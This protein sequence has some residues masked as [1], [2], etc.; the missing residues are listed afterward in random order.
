M[1]TKTVIA[2][3]A[4]GIAALSVNPARAGGFHLSIGLP[5]PPIPFVTVLAPCPSPV[6]C[7]PAP[8]IYAPPPVVCISAPVV[9]A[10]PPV[11]YPAVWGPGHGYNAGHRGWERH[12][13]LA[14]GHRR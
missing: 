2:L 4:I 11:C 8:V 9:C 12:G 1:K 3:A 14:W 10:P 13:A 7:A 5:L 6:I